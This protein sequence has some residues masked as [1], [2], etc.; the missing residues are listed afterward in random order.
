MPFDRLK[1]DVQRWGFAKSLYIRVMRRLQEWL[2]FRLFVVHTRLLDPD[3]PR[4]PIPE[5]CSVRVLDEHEL[6]EFS[7]NP[8]LG[9]S[10]AFIS[11]ASARG[12]VCFGYL[13]RD[14]LV[15]YTWVANKTAPAEDGF[16]VLFRPEYSYG[17]KALTLPSHR[18]QHL[19]EHIVHLTDRWQ[20]AHGR[21]Y[22]IDYI[23][24]LNLASIAADRRYGN[25]PVGYAGYLRWFGS[26]V[27]FHSPGVR[28]H[29]FSFHLPTSANAL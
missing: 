16:W 12:D 13:E 26:R 6:Q 10:D 18:G 1:E 23:D 22:N 20:T 9:L 11:A 17:Y 3:A 29:R 27:P 24:T 7:R 28:A 5:D 19:Q 2:R 15:A 8:E 14:D 25:R 4:N 21:R